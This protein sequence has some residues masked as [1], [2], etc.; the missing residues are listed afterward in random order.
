MSDSLKPQD[1]AKLTDIFR[2]L[3]NNSAL[4]L[5]DDLTA[6]QVP[7]W[8]S[9]NNINLF[10]QIEEDFGIRFTTEEITSLANVGELKTMVVRKLSAR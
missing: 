5:R 2:T 4:V 9:F 3:F 6:P 7:G 10:M 8:D 1:D